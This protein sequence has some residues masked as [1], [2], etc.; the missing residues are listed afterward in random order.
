MN[1]D[2]GIIGAGVAGA[3]AALRLIE[4]TSNAKFVLFDIGK[5]PGKRRR[6]LEGWFGSFPNSDGKLYE[7]DLDRVSELTGDKPVQ[8]LNGWL[9]K[10][11]KK[12]SQM[13]VINTKRPN[14][15][16]LDLAAKNGF[17]VDFEDYVQFKP[18]N[19]H[20][21]SKFIA[22]QLENSSS[23]EYSFDNEVFD[24][25]KSNGQFILNTQNGEFTCNK[26]IFCPGRSGWRWAAKVYRDF[27]IIQEDKFAKF[28]MRIEISSQYMKE[29]NKSHCTLTN[30]RG[31]IVGPLS[32]FGTIIPEDHSIP[33]GDYPGATENSYLSISAFRSN[34]NRWKTDKV[35]F[36]LIG[37]RPVKDSGWY[38]T[39][40]LAKLAFL[41]SED[42]VGKEKIKPFL[43][44]KSELSKIPEYQWLVQEI[45]EL[46]KVIPNIIQRGYFH[47][48]DIIATPP[49]ILIGNN[50]ETEVENLF[51]AGESAGIRGIRAAA[52]MGG[53]AADS[54]NK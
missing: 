36:S 43:K 10:H 26:L 14:L 12:F 28:G 49:E 38:Q 23:L 6:Q 9:N 46:A 30:D 19:I 8:N 51:V 20:G 17:K 40:R 16:T 50:L 37:N 5:K 11:L 33:E 7:R 42:R 31:I 25:T 39:D 22:D 2:V 48:P 13:K 54:V 41:L 47:V 45:T 44:G 34:E 29:F 1:Y 27:G 52:I 53:I 4:Q 21:I 32:W 35:S 24:I 3:F 18:E 15:K